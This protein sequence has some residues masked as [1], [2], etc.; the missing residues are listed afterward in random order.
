VKF[1]APYMEI[2]GT[3]PYGSLE[4]IKEAGFNG[5]ECFLIGELRSERRANTIVEKASRLKIGLRFHQG[6]SRESGQP[7]MANNLLWALGAL[8]PKHMS[9]EQQLDPAA[10]DPVVLYGNFAGDYVCENY[11]YQTASL[12]AKSG[13]YVQTF[14]WFVSKVRTHKL[15]V[16]FD[17]QHVLEWFYNV[18][19]VSDLTMD[20]EKIRDV[21]F[22]LWEH[23]SPLVKEI[24]L[25]DFD[26]SLGGELGR[27]VFPGTGVFP[28][29]E[30]FADVKD[31]G[32]VGTI[33]PEVNKRYLRNKEDLKRL[34]E[35]AWQLYY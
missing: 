16:V 20:R 32:W 1:Y 25:C 28:F 33:T 8:V 9:L 12:H 5:A 4:D 19:S 7:S 24:H 21:V 2:M 35:V 30:F 31:S 10:A 23:L 13:G 34:R 22:K 17:T 3:K 14:D 18:Q 26:P 11:L 27:N 29:R 15:P 6:W